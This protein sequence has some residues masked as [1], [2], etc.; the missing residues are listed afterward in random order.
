[1]SFHWQPDLS[2][3][4][5]NAGLNLSCYIREQLDLLIMFVGDPKNRT[6]EASSFLFD[7]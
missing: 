7:S 6:P 2:K 1:M 5:S 4:L 3:F